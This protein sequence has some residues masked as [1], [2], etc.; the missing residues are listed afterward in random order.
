MRLS[1]HYG[2]P[3]GRAEL[4]L[5][6]SAQ[7]AVFSRRATSKAERRELV[8]LTSGASTRIHSCIRRCDTDS[9][10]RGSG[11]LLPK[12]NHFPARPRAFDSPEVER[13]TCGGTEAGGSARSATIRPRAVPRTIPA[14]NVHAASSRPWCGMLPVCRLGRMWGWRLLLLVHSVNNVPHFLNSFP[15]FPSSFPLISDRAGDGERRRPLRSA[16]WSDAERAPASPFRLDGG[17]TPADQ[18]EPLELTRRA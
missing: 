6:S 15:S 10:L 14:C 9:T 12:R 5:F 11:T 4:A 1:W 2:V 7:E 17:L 18:I 8:S 13:P 16:R 3:C